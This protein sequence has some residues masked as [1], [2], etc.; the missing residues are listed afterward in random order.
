[1]DWLIIGEKI[2][3]WRAFKGIKQEV[4]AKEIGISRVMLSRYENGKTPIS[5]QQIELI[6]ERL[7]IKTEDIIKI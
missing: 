6:A 3:R 4:F 2:K 1:M 5:L 7:G